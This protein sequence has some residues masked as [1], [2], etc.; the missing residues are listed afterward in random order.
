M[1]KGL[2]ENCLGNNR[3]SVTSV[4]YSLENNLIVKKI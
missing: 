4:I 1:G 3:P 2:Y